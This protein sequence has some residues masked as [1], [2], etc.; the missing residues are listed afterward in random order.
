MGVHHGW[1]RTLKDI[2]QRYRAMQGF[3]LLYQNGFDCQ[4]LWVEVGVEKE[5]GLNSKR[6]IEEYGLER[7]AR[8]CRD[9]EALEAVLLDLALRV[10][11]ELLL[12]PD[13]HP[14]PLAVEPVLV[15]QVEPLH[16]PIALPDVLERPAPAVVHA[17][18]VVGR[19]RA[20]DE[21]ERRAAAVSVTER[22]QS[23]LTLPALEGAVLEADVV[24]LGGDSLER[25]HPRI[26]FRVPACPGSVQRADASGQERMSWRQVLVK[27]VLVQILVERRVLGQIARQLGKPEL[28]P[29]RQPTLVDLHVLFVQLIHGRF[30]Q[31]GPLSGSRDFRPR[32]RSPSRRGRWW[33]R[34]PPGRGPAFP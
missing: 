27:L 19:D 14:E 26:L 22:L 1:G 24:G 33:T 28:E 7:F 34:N 15:E 17:H 12:D 11:A 10:E 4:G 31:T 18:G 3:D 25:R 32:L 8:A 21:A 20:V 16:G 6:E 13:L 2:W 29:L 30:L 5:L 9:R 23:A